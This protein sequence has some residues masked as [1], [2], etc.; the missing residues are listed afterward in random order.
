MLLAE[1]GRASVALLAAALLDPG[2]KG[3]DGRSGH[4]L[5]ASV[6]ST[7]AAHDPGAADAW[8]PSLCD[9]QDVART[10]GGDSKRGLTADEGNRSRLEEAVEVANAHRRRDGPR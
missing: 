6:M 9:A 8:D 3:E 5:I 7:L 2:Q 4:S 1:E 10:V